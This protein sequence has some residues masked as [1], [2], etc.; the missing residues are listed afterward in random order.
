MTISTGLPQ[1]CFS[2]PVLFTLYTN[3]CTSHTENQ[4]II[5]YSDNTAILGLMLTNSDVQVYKSTIQN[6][7]QWCDKH[8]LI[9]NTKKT[10]MVFDPKCLGDHSSVVIHDHTIAQVDSYMYLGIHMDNKL[11]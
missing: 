11:V 4:Y 10:E 3:E 7:V 5:K 1:G 2:S 8:H 9:L 6:F